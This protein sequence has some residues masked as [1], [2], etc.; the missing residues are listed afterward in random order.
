WTIDSDE[1][2]HF[3]N[4]AN[5]STVHPELPGVRPI[6]FV[7]DESGQTIPLLSVGGTLRQVPV[8]EI[9]ANGWR[10]V[11]VDRDSVEVSDGTQS[12]RLP[13]DRLERSL[14]SSS[15]AQ[16]QPASAPAND[17]SN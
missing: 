14:S 16:P 1:L 10:V 6:G 13:F 2:Q 8:G 5:R 9:V 11:G 12:L 7:E 3:S 17:E 4:R 15:D